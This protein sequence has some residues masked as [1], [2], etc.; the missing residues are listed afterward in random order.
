MKQLKSHVRHEN[1]EIMS[2]S[3]IHVLICLPQLVLLFHLRCRRRL[4]SWCLL[5]RLENL[6]RVDPRPYFGL[7]TQTQT[8]QGVQC[9]TPRTCP[10]GV[11]SS[12]T[13]WPKEVGRP[14]L[15]LPWRLSR[16]SPITNEEG[17]LRMSMTT[18]RGKCR[19]KR[20]NRFIRS[21]L[22]FDR[23]AAQRGRLVM[24]LSTMPF[25]PHRQRKIS[26]SLC[27]RPWWEKMKARYVATFLFIPTALLSS[28]LYFVSLLILTHRISLSLYY[29]VLP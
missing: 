12:R 16:K 23:R 15:H 29:A 6:C 17:P 20:K 18:P 26:Q 24:S 8:L 27:T 4:P 13:L 10:S 19:A 3:H 22:S 14:T 11:F 28:P 2:I 21:W 25:S 1:P 5:V 7:L 9:T